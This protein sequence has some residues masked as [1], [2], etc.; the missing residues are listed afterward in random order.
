[1]SDEMLKLVIGGVLLVH[2]LG[3][4]GA[5]G[6]LLWIRLRPRSSS[7]DWSAARTWLM[8]SLPAETAATLAT[9]FWLAALVGFVIAALSFWSLVL[10]ADV[11]RSVALGSAVVS[12][13]GII[14]FFGTWPAFNTLAATAVNVAVLV[15]I[16]LQWPPQSVLGA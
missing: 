12:M 7:G 5:L 10:P 14:L 11:W 2:G 13:T 3:H 9:A 4:A 15:A 1:M 16:W 8:P 6:A